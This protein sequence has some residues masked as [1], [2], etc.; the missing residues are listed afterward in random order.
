[1]AGLGGLRNGVDLLAVAHY[2]HQ[3]G[4]RWQITIPRIVLHKLKVPETLPC[5]GIEGNQRIRK[6]VVA[7]AIGAIE[8]VRG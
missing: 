7:V 8:I 5:V 3:S 6:Q 1:M 4:R 2:R